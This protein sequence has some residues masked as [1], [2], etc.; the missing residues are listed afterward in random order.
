MLLVVH[1]GVIR[2]IAEK[3]LGKPLAEGEP[4]LGGAV[5]LSRIADGSWFLG[6]RSSNPPALDRQAASEAR[7][8]A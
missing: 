4:E 1:K 6:R 5:G 2:V 3:L 8:E 7:S